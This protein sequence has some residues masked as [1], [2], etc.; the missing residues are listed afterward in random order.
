MNFKETA[1]Y[2]I[3]ESEKQSGM[4]LK[5]PIRTLF[6]NILAGYGKFY[7]EKGLTDSLNTSTTEKSNGR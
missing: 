5:E 2:T 4:K 1:E 6:L 3:K 7:Y